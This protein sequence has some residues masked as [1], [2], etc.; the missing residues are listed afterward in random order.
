[1]MDVSKLK[2]LMLNAGFIDVKVQ[3]IRIEIG[4]PTD[5]NLIPQFAFVNGRS[6]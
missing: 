3:K 2:Q 5:G 1:M 6:N 4:T